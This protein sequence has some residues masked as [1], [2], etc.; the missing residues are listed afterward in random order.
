MPLLKAQTLEEILDRRLVL[1]YASRTG[2]APTPEEIDAELN[3]LKARLASLRQSLADY[4]KGESITENDLKRQIAWNLVWEK[5]LAQYVTEARLETY[6]QTHLRDFDGSEVSV[7]HILLRIE[8]NSGPG[9]LADLLKRAA[10]IRQE[11]VSGKISFAQAAGKYSAGPSAKDGGQ[12]GFIPRHGVMDEA[13]SRAAFALE[14]GQVS[15]PVQTPF[16]VHLLYCNEIKPGDKKLN[17][18]RKELDEAL[19]RELLEKLAQL[20]RPYTPVKYTGKMPYLK[21]GTRE[22]VAP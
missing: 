12:L 21:P 18:V 17:D 22:L 6:F 14:A 15:E 1:A 11:I 3:K 4:L 16:G 7:S 5:Y 9:A 10:A 20:Q 2:S 13:F 8:K 19:A